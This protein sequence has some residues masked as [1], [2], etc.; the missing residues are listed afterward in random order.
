MMD[1]Y[2]V[3]VYVPAYAV[4][5]TATAN[6]KVSFAGPSPVPGA[7]VKMVIPVAGAVDPAGT[8]SAG[9]YEMEFVGRAQFPVPAVRDET[10]VMV[11]AVVGSVWPEP[12][13]NVVEVTARLQPFPVPV[14]SFVVR[15]RLPV[16]VWV[17]P[18]SVTPGTVMD[19]GA[20]RESA[21]PEQIV[22]NCATNGAPAA[23]SPTSQQ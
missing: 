17:E 20:A 10:P 8:V 22:P 21:P 2:H 4:A 1:T 3:E 6:E 13:V 9:E 12:V 11:D 14:S 23:V 5:G 15:A 16:V 19:A 7:A 18:L